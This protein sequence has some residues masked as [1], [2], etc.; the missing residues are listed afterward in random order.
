MTSNNPWVVKPAKTY[1]PLPAA[2][3]VADFTGV[4]DFTLPQT[5]EAKWKWQFRVATGEHKDKTTDTLTD[6]D[7]NPN[8]K[9]GRIIRGLLGR[10]LVAGEDVKASIVARKGQTY[11]IDVRPGPKG[12]KTGVQSVSAPPPAM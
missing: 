3:Y 11:M 12:G 5:G 9:A 10:D 4:E 2:F 6:P 8:T 1:A 7:I